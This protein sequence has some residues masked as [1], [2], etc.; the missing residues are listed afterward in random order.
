[1]MRALPVLSLAVFVSG[2]AGAA[3]APTTSAFFARQQAPLDGWAAQEGGTRGGAGAA[4]VVTVRDAAGLRRA[5]S[6]KQAGSRIVQVEGI[7][8]MSEGRPFATTADQ[9]KRGRVALPGDTTLVG[10]GTDAG[11]VNAHIEVKDVSQVIIRNLNLRNP[12]D[13]APEW[14]PKDGATGNWNAQFDA[15]SIVGARHVWVD[16]NSFTDAPFTDDQLPTENGKHKQCH[17]GALDIRDAADFVTVSYNRFAL[18]QKNML[19]GASDKA[20]GDAGHLRVSISNN[21]FEYVASRAPRVRFGQVHLFNN[22]HVGDRRHPGYRHEYSV[23]V[24]K[25]ARI[26][27]HANAFD[28]A[29]ARSCQD[30][31]RPFETDAADAGVYTDSGS[32]LN[33]QPL[34]SCGQAPTPAW[35]VPYAF[36]PRP[37]EAVAAHVLAQAGAGKLAERSA[38][39]R[40]PSADYLACDGFDAGG[41]PAWDIGMSGTAPLDLLPEAKGSSNRVLQVGGSGSMLVL[42]KDPAV[43]A[44]A[45]RA[46]FVEARLRAAPGVQGTRRLTMLGRYLDAGNWVGAAIELPA[47][48]DT[49]LVQLVKMENGVLSRLKSV[50]RARLA[51]NRFA[52]LRL[53][54]APG[55]LTA[56]LDGE[57]ITTAPQP[58]FAAGTARLGW[59]TEGGGLALDD[60]RIGIPGMQPPRI[61]PSLSGPSFKAQAGDPPQFLGIGATGSDGVTRLPYAARSSNPA[62]ASVKLAEG[63]ILVTPK[64]P[65]SAQIVLTSLADPALQ[66]TVDATI[67]KPFAAFGMPVPN[68]LWPA[69]GAR[70]VPADTPLRIAFDSAPRLGSEGAVR[71]L[72]KADKS[73]VDIVRVGEEVRAIGYPGQPRSRHVRFAPIAV[74]GNALLIQP[75]TGKLAPGEEYDVLVGDGVVSEGSI[76]GLPFR[77]IGQAAGWSFRTAAAVPQGAR[78]TVDDDGPADF[79]TVQG[80]LN[81]AMRTLSKAAPVTIDVRN[82]RYRELL[83]VLGKD[84]ITLRGE[85][86]DGVVIHAT[87]NDGLNPG[88]G[89]SQ[90]LGS[91]SFSG[92]RALLAVEETD[93]LTLENL[94]LRNTTLR[95]NTRSGQAET[96]Y[97]N[98]DGGRLV[99]KNASFFSEQDTIQVKGYAWFW[100]T[101]IEGNVDFVWGANRAALFEESELRSVGDSGNPSSGG[102][103]VQAR[104]VSASDPGFVFLNSAL[105]HGPGPKGNGVPRGA[106]Y[107]ARSPGTAS[108]W[109]NVAFINCRMGEHLAPVGWAGLGVNREPA[110]NPAPANAAQGWREYGSMDL[111]G[112]PL[113]LSKRVGGYLLRADEVKERFGSR[114]AIFAGFNGGQGWDPQP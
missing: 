41:S 26:V 75:H 49:M 99:A 67:G 113:D 25:G 89:I 54:M 111:A 78:L 17:D 85:S 45:G 79:R 30:A 61:A 2:L 81:H 55:M 88:S 77:G 22:Y 35:T 96:V 91:P 114:K 34:G 107:L 27:S 63:G 29:G 94:T 10:L 72:R 90:G 3:P 108:T 80:A 68:T 44:L 73:L 104:T 23:G 65:G 11:F 83:F 33:G 46:L 62:V 86:R 58:P 59:Q 95:A 71:I 39:A 36:V 19:I 9:E 1:M 87:N 18:H 53:E 51:D 93:L 8:D 43:A 106:T 37:A 7:I 20:T 48:G 66:T 105:T 15:I 21:L 28:I 97:F 52:T 64:A 40:C 31:V 42:S 60:V 103:V 6:R 56:W 57:K 24:A 98:S 112:K 110:P 74:D 47:G 5:L 69:I 109:D 100:R 13:V 50:P 92:G 82:G 14:D 12:C 32:L 16:H 101:L 38:A 84:N 4:S 76:G 102:F 70:E